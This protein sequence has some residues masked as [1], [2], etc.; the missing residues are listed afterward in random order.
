MASPPQPRRRRR[1]L[2]E[3]AGASFLSARADSLHGQ[4]LIT[5]AE[6]AAD[7]RTT[8]SWLPCV[9][10]AGA[11]AVQAYQAEGAADERASHDRCR[12]CVEARAEVAAGAQSSLNL[13]SRRSRLGPLGAWGAA[14]PS[15]T[16]RT[17]L[18]AHSE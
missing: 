11:Q 14:K 1:W 5:R 10:A 3:G 18:P 7:E 4:T 8:S 9:E 6:G 17:T 16:A 15:A 2:P 13:Q 12:A